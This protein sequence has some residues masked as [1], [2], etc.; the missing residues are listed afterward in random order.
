VFHGRRSISRKMSRPWNHGLS[1]S[2]TMVYSRKSQLYT[3]LKACSTLELLTQ[4]DRGEKLTKHFFQQLTQPES[5][6]N[7]NMI[8][9]IMS[10]PISCMWILKTR[11]LWYA[12]LRNSHTV[13][14]ILLKNFFLLLH[15]LCVVLSSSLWLQYTDTLVSFIVPWVRTPW[16]V[17]RWSTAWDGA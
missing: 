13:W 9:L 6:L 4:N 7:Q 8:F 2:L 12:K 15:I 17:L 1:W 5:C 11:T 3:M 16:L 10:A 14:L